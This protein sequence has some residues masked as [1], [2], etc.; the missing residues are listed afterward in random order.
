[1]KAKILFSVLFMVMVFFA[2]EKDTITP[3]LF[4]AKKVLVM[5]ESQLHQRGWGPKGVPFMPAYFEAKKDV[6]D[7]PHGFCNDMETMPGVKAVRVEESARMARVELAD[8]RT[9]RIYFSGYQNT[10]KEDLRERVLEDIGMKN[11]AYVDRIVSYINL[12]FKV[13]HDMAFDPVDARTILDFYEM[14]GTAITV[15]QG[16]YP[17]MITKNKPPHAI[18]FEAP[19]IVE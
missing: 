18:Y 9:L 12:T 16:T 4:C 11:E 15:Q 7:M 8:R 2:C 10:P 13:P 19:I 17:L 6:C 1:M 14:K 3:D 5:N